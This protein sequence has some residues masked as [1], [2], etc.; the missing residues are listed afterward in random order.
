MPTVASRPAPGPATGILSRGLSLH[1]RLVGIACGSV[2]CLLMMGAVT[3]AALQLKVQ[4]IDKGHIEVF[5]QLNVLSVNIRRLLD[6]LNKSYSLECT[7]ENRSRLRS[8]MFKHPTVGDIGILDS[9]GQLTCNTTIGLIDP[10]QPAVRGGLDGKAGRYL[11]QAPLPLADEVFKA[12]LVQRGRFQLA[13]GANPIRD[14]QSRY[15]DSFWA[16]R[17]DQRARIWHSPRAELADSQVTPDTPHLQVRTDTGVFLISN[18]MP[19]YTLFSA[20]S[21]LRFENLYQ[22]HVA[23]MAG[24]S[25]LCLLLGFLGAD[26]V[27]R[28]CRHLQS[29]DYRIRYLCTPDN[30]VCYYQP[31]LELATGRIIGCEVL[32][33]LRD[34]QVLVYPDQFIPALTRC[35]LGWAFDEAVSGR[36]LRELGNSLPPQS[37]FKIA[38]NFFPKNLQRD[39][40]HPLLQTNLQATG[41][42]DLQIELEVTEYNFSPEIVP[43]LQRLKADGYL[44]AIDDFGTGYSNLGMVKRVAPDI[45]KIDRSFVFE[46]E[47]DSL[48]SSLIPEI[49][50]IAKAVNSQVVAE[51]IEN[52]AQATQLAALGVQYGQGYHF[53]KPMPLQD[54]LAYLKAKLETAPAATP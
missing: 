17:G 49:V 29:M 34:G 9:Q 1:P 4:E 26:A 11:L 6:E 52:A 37:D 27:T 45:L 18:T 28:R 50:A 33:R 8:L 36:A 53:A 10:P 40:V 13:I 15:T 23:L 7:P 24:A 30:V 32:A 47:D 14:L 44:I 21:V 31:I 46:M 42:H 41:R 3:M 38:L 5:H 12:T 35:E 16:G 51:G 39:T 2:L 54:F 43:E 25:G 22:G 20:Q 48:R 19:N